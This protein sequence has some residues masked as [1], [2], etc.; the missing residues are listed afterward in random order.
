MTVIVSFLLQKLCQV[1]EVELCLSHSKLSKIMLLDLS[2]QNLFAA[3]AAADDDDNNNN[4][5]NNNFTLL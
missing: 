4:N 2:Y 5:N 3:A 1:C